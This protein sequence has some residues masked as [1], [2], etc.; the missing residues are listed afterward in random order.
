MKFYHS[1]SQLLCDLMPDWV[2]VVL[3]QTSEPTLPFLFQPKS[4]S[5]AVISRGESPSISTT[6]FTAWEGAQEPVI[7]DLGITE[8]GIM[9]SGIIWEIGNEY[10]RK[11]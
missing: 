6:S 5:G 8:S 4:E 10:N 9:E 11:W 2:N 1:L 3:W 7:M